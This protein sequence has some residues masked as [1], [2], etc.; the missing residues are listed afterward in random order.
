MYHLS[1]INLINKAAF[2]GYV[3]SRHMHE[4]GRLGE[5]DTIH[6]VGAFLFDKP[7]GLVMVRRV[8]ER[9]LAVSWLYVCPRY[10]NKGV[11]AALIGALEKMAGPGDGGK[12]SFSYNS[13]SPFAVQIEALLAKT[14]FEKP[15]VS[16]CF[17]KT[18]CAA[19]LEL[20]WVKRYVCKDLLER[21]I[22]Q[23]GKY[24]LFRW[25]EL[26]DREKEYLKEIKG[27]LYPDWFCPLN[28]E[29]KNDPFLSLGIRHQDEL[30]GYLVTRREGNDTLYIWRS[31][32][33]DEYRGS[34]L[35]VTLFSTV[36]HLQGRAGIR[37]F[38]SDIEESNT[39]TI[40]F[41]I[42]AFEKKNMEVHRWNVMMAEK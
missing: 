26:K 32:L 40:K 8:G 39:R 14:G 28:E 17:F 13:D 23:F 25:S 16:L 21:R 3:P 31:Y 19:A 15:N 35:Y 37:Y 11:G 20:G 27:R 2:A 9:N 10:R 36:L 34:S 33:R 18:E 24:E 1:E 42:H 30:I 38:M 5:D 29:K 22:A 4:F 6:G 7:I 41:A 12:I